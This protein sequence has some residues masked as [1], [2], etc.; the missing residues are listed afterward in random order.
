LGG[1]SGRRH[2]P[3]GREFARLAQAF[4]GAIAGRR[5]PDADASRIAGQDDQ[6]YLRVEMDE[7]DAVL[8]SDG[9]SDGGTR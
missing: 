2:D 3:D 8:A 5:F 7:V 4:D 6:A 9:P 1:E